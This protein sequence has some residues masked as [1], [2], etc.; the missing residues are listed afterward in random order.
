M[1]ELKPKKFSIGILAILIWLAINAIFMVLELT[2]FNDAADP[3]NT[4]ILVLS[5]ASIASL[6]LSTKYGIAIT[7][8]SVIY[9]FSFNAFNLLYFGTS[10]LNIIS[11][12]ING[13]ITV[14][15]MVSLLRK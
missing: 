6:L 14:F 5:V 15:L 3:N 9:A 2:V 1:S 8:F 7:T 4:I 11:A 13:V 12:T 10:V